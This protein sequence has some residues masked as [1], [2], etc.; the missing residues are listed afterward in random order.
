MNM[1]A[2]S[3]RFLARRACDLMSRDLVLVPREMSLP[4]A[5]HLLAQARVSGA[6]VVDEDGRCIGV[7]SNTDF[8]RFAD[9]T[10]SAPAPEPTADVFQP[11]DIVRVDQPHGVRVSDCMTRDPV[12][13]TSQATIQELA[14]MMIDARIHRVVVVDSDQR[15]IGIVSS[16]DILAAVAY[17]D[18][19]P[20]ERSRPCEAT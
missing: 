2:T 8:V 18:G 5:A 7:L 15:P 11:W 17:A 12:V 1:V 19:A 10:R 14:R 20:E 9:K 3:N 13:V 4:G 16:T 6:P